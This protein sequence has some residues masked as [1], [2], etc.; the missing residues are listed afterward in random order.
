V[1]Q[2]PLNIFVIVVAGVSLHFVFLAFNWTMTT[3][4][5]RLTVWRCRLEPVFAS[6][7]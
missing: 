4:V 7:G 2:T 5:L 3:P 1:G 6:T